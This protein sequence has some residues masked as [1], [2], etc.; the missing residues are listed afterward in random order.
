MVAEPDAQGGFARSQCHREGR[1]V[2]CQQ[3]RGSI[4]GPGA[5]H[6]QFELI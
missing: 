4:E 6:F 5:S 1:H 3:P 2:H